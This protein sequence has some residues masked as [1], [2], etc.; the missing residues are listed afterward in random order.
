MTLRGYGVATGSEAVV[1]AGG[2]LTLNLASIAIAP[3]GSATGTA[4][5][6]DPSFF[7]EGGFSSYALIADQVAFADGMTLAP[8][9]QTLVADSSLY[10]HP[11]A[12]GLA[13]VASL[14]TFAAEQRPGTALT[15][16]AA[17]DIV[18]PAGTI[19][20]PG[21]GGRVSLT[22]DNVTVRGVI[23][24]PAGAIAVA[25]SNVTVESTARMLARGATRIITDF[26]GERGGT[27][28]D[29]GSVNLDAL[30]EIAIQ[31]GALIDVSGTS[32]VIDVVEGGN[33]R[34][35]S[36]PLTL[37]S[38]GGSIN[39]SAVG[40][41]IEGTLIGNPG[42]PG[43]SGG[44]LGITLA[45]SGASALDQLKDVLLVLQPGCYGYG[46]GNCDGVSWQDSVGF[47]FGLLFAD[48]GYEYTPIIFTQ[49][50]VD[51]VATGGGILVSARATPSGGVD[52]AQ[53][54]LSE[55]A[56]VYLADVFGDISGLFAQTKT[57]TVRPQA[58][59]SGG[60]G[61]LSLSGAAVKL[62]AV[63]IALPGSIAISGSLLNYNGT[64]SRLSA[65]SLR[66][67]G[68][69]VVAPPAAALGGELTLSAS[70]IDVGD[71]GIRG[72]A[73]TNINTTDLRLS[74]GFDVDGK[75]VISA[76]QIFPFTQTAA[77][78]SASQSITILAN[79]E[80]PAL[81]F[82]AGGTLTLNAPIIDQR[83]TLRAPFGQIVLNATDAL[84]LGE[85]SITSVSGAGLTMLYGT[86]ADLT[87]WYG[88]DLTA[89][90]TAPPEKRITL[91]APN[92]DARSGAVID[93]SGGGDLL[94]YQFVPGSGGSSNYLATSDAVAIMP[95][96]KVSAIDRQ[97][98]IHLDGGYGI[99]A[100]DYAVLPASYALLPGAYRLVPFTNKGQPIYGTR[101]AT[102]LADGS[103][104][105]AGW[106]SITGTGVYDQRAQTY[107]VSPI[108]TSRLYSEYKIWTANDYF[109]S[110][111]FV[112]AMRR[113]SG[114][115]VTA[116]PRLPMDAGALQ[117]EA[118]VAVSLN[119]TLLGSAEAG[120]RG[121]VVDISAD[122][123]AV[124]GGVDAAGYRAAGY[125]VLDAGQLSAFGSESL[126]LGGTRKQTVSGL[127]VD[128]VASNVV[129]ATDGS[130]ATALVAPEI[131]L[132]SEQIIDI[133][134]GSIVEARGTIGGGSGNI[135]IKPVIAA[136]IDTKGTTDTSD[137]V[138][139]TPAVD[140]GAFVRVSNG[141]S[142]KAVRTGAVNTQ[143]TLSIGAA[144]LRGKT[145]ILD[146]TRTTTVA[147][148]A[149]LRATVLDVSSG[150]ISIG[151]PTGTPDGLVLSGSSLEALAAASSLTLR[152][153]SS[154]DFYGNAT[155]GTR[156]A[157]GSFG[158]GKLE[159]DAASLNGATGAHVTIAAG[160]VLFTNGSGAT[161]PGLGGSG[162]TLV[163]NAETITLGT[164]AK[165]RRR[166]RPRC[167]RSRQGDPR[168]RRRNHR[169]RIR[170]SR[171][172][173]AAAERRERRRAG[174]DDDRRVPVD[175]HIF[176]CGR[177]HAR[178]KALHY[179]CLDRTG[180]PD[181]SRG[182]LAQPAR[183][184]R[185][186]R[187]DKRVGDARRGR[188][189]E[190]L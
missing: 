104:V 71:A 92:I 30:D 29:G 151:S 176:C 11:S 8:T 82:S 48:S 108:E 3:S 75:L 109:A 47:D 62:D 65:T 180:R 103:V 97:Q 81:P 156:G 118:T 155:I 159:F 136:V 39:I 172:R 89:P 57:L 50:L 69:G 150:R 12:A 146:A 80:A 148:N 6:L 152:S 24:A 68:S 145:I 86:I 70:S 41:M 31:R 120:G 40:G 90:L 139:T 18:L 189:P 128:A 43:A 102:Q 181:R 182:R 138:V 112:A 153:Y 188:G 164:G 119:G 58:F 20:A 91:K 129:I 14:R 167:S 61:G 52:P 72:Y 162:G 36:H 149:D 96:S 124:V 85:G 165:S 143:G 179:G 46:N 38:N 77:T 123:I 140:Y 114:L 170:Q 166:I 26:R 15:F 60:F 126:L 130:A 161:A 16:K 49:A 132:A 64:P 163:V 44:G 59:A 175:G 9:P 190:F 137:D 154:I 17:G 111:E 135:L 19:L 56:F 66:I 93:L 185:R 122:K 158:L 4:T 84:T 42:G 37:A 32:G 35:G 186:C 83:G 21:I 105:M 141:E 171:L 107:R 1:S 131:L 73:Q 99:P 100:G 53:Y 147:A 115:E 113:Q 101:H 34:D 45:A 54:G 98:V 133:A 13:Q 63:S 117:I 25:G 169:L 173:R 160:E 125:L 142:L 134:S 127:E 121:A 157:D 33:V 184:Q 5:R 183:D 10:T 168:S 22:G 76:G 7:S 95:V 2:T 178:R 78:I 177:G 144:T 55:T 79:G 23:D 174:L 94:A 87:L 67:A 88:N 106:S 187:A 110:S 51:A 74:G 27:V 116:L 28:H